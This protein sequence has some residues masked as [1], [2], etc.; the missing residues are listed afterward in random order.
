MDASQEMIALGSCQLLGSFVGSM[1]VTASFGRSAVN[2]ASGVRT[3]FGGIVTGVI[4]L[5]ACAFLTPHFAY[6]PTSA[7]SA[8]IISAMIFTID[9]DILLP[10]WRSKS[11]LKTLILRSTTPFQHFL[12]SEVD[13]IP[14][15]LTFFLGLFVSVEVGMIAGTLTHLAMLVFSASRPKVTVTQG[16]V[17]LKFRP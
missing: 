17:S 5:L 7:L 15:S 6:I 1:P 14:Y 10:I 12:F 3:P 11:E 16:K 9:I 13:L 2:G 8:V 4:I